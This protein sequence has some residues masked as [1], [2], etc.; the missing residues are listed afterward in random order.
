MRRLAQKCVAAAAFERGY[1]TPLRSSVPPI[2]SPPLPYIQTYIDTYIHTYK[3][4]LEMQNLR[5]VSIFCDG[6]G[7]GKA[8]LQWAPVSSLLFTTSAKARN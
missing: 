1:T 7:K 3:V 8:V 4:S 6:N 2:W 5:Y